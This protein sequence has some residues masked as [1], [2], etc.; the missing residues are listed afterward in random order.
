[1]LTLDKKKLSKDQLKI[2]NSYNNAISKAKALMNGKELKPVSK[3]PASEAGELIDEFLE[4]EILKKR[5]EFKEKFGKILSN[6]VAFD[7]FVV[8]K[9]QEMLKAIMDKKKEFASEINE[10][11]SIIEGI[12]K[13]KAEYESALD[14]TNEENNSTSVEEEGE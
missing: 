5:K 4:E 10:A 8:Q 3:V 1:M 7:R 13:L 2:E 12:D 6:K 9:E 11:V 14:T